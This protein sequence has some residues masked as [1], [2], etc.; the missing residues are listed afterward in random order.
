M[1]HSL[2]IIFLFFNGLTV[3]AQNREFLGEYRIGIIGKDK[4]NVTYQ[5]AHRGA[6]AA[7]L[8]LSRKYSIDVE[9][10]V[11][12]P[13][14]SKGENQINAMA[15]L[16]IENADG[17]VISPLDTRAHRA[18]IDFAISN[19]QEIVFF[20]NKLTNYQP[21]ALILADEIEAGRMAGREILKI[22]PFNGRVAILTT[23]RPSFALEQRMKGLREVLGYRRVE[24]V[25]TC[26]PEY[27][28]SI[29][30]IH[31]AEKTDRNDLIK[32]WVFLGDWPLLGLPALPWKPKKMPAVAIQSSPSA[33]IYIEQ[34]YLNALVVHPYYDWGYKSVETVIEKLHNRRNPEKHTIKT[35]PQLVNRRNTESYRESWKKWL[36]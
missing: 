10:V 33:I 28:S 29:D 4:E 14:K 6:Q 35:I 7:A 21:L 30:A 22:I 24:T 36:K 17:L 26:L 13:E 1:T 34:S 19:G 16:F 2:L 20:E 15:Q 25:V 12:T 9:L 3:F 18:S 5:A 8:A 31:E 32:G 23:D 11:Y 27:K